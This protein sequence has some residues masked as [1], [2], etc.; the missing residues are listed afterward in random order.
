MKRDREMYLK[1]KP[2]ADDL[3]KAESWCDLDGV[4]NR[5]QTVKNLYEMGYRKQNEGTWIEHPHIDYFGF[6]AGAH[7]EC[8]NCHFDD[9][10]NLDN[11]NYCPKCG[12]KMKGGE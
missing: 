5:Y 2:M 11:I 10:Y 1:F 7:Y 4:L 9:I 3:R 8:S 12:A 6:Y